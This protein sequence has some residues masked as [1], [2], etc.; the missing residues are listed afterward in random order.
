MI[1]RYVSFALVLA[2]AFVFTVAATAAPKVQ[3]VPVKQGSRLLV[4]GKLVALFRTPN[5]SL[6]PQQRAEFA[7]RRLNELVKSDLSAEDIDVRDRG[8]DWGV[9]ASGGLVMIATAEEAKE[10]D[11]D[12]EAVARLWATN[13]KAALGGART[14]SAKGRPG[15]SKKAAPKPPRIALS[16]ESLAVPVN[17]TRRIAVSGTAVGPILTSTDGDPCATVDVDM[18]TGEISVLGK[19]PGKMTLRV[20]RGSAV[21]EL[22]IWVKKYAGRLGEVAQA[23]VTGTMSPGSLVRQV[24]EEC[25]LEGVEREPGA[26]VRLA[27]APSGVRA[28]PRGESADVTF[29][30]TITGEGYLPVKT[31]A[32]VTV[33]NRTLPQ[34]DAGVLLYSNDP[35][36]IREYG[37]LYQG[38]VDSEESTRLMFHHQN[39]T[40]RT[41]TFQVH[42][43]N[44]NDEPTEVQVIQ[45]EAG[46]VLDTIQ[47]GHRA[48]Q[49]YL[50]AMKG[51]VGYVLQVPAKGVR[52]VYST[53]MPQLLTVSG[54]Y[55][56]RVL[57]GGPLVTEVTS[58]AGP[59]RPT[60][61]P[62]LL[63]TA[64]SEP[65]T[66]PNPQKD[67]AYQYV[68]GER[69]TF[70]P[71]GR[72]PIS[73]TRANRK[74]FG[75]YGVLYNITV[76]LSNPTSET[77]TVR[78]LMTPEADWA[79]GAFFVDGQLVEAKQVAPPGE[80]EL[81]S[82]KLGPQEQR[83]LRIQGIPVGGSAYPVSLVVR[84]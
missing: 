23:E 58:S 26:I 20:S 47:V 35:E 48:G 55:G 5:G 24:A 22:T 33:R 64:R 54:I 7:A 16:E 51:D 39:R 79:R 65:H 31:A 75:N 25:F 49:K 68:V 60:I 29:P 8:G 61:T 69:W 77:K 41:V 32:R 62:D 46:P 37:T 78:L 53:A 4:A 73:G 6:S 15:R 59:T 84:S 28:L 19:T 40:G 70:M 74:L 12:S 1:K 10:R 82:V 56:F 50:S 11:E 71:M 34:Q 57:E 66:Y 30:I 38:L 36:S 63:T 52:T 83:T 45:A 44:P 80:A 42:L 18:A 76:S 2:A 17:E 81:W 13:L 9:Y 67:Q 72:Q 27:G 43:L 21:A 14:A 3:V